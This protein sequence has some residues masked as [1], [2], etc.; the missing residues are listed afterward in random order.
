M[1]IGLVLPGR[2]LARVVCTGRIWTMVGVAALT[3]LSGM[4][5]LVWPVRRDDEMR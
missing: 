2:F 5:A 1:M 3:R 4:M